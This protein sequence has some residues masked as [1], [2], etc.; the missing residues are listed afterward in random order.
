M[1]FANPPGIAAFMQDNVGY[2]EIGGRAIKDAVDQ[3]LTTMGTMGQAQSTG[4]ATIAR[5]RA[6]DLRREAQMYAN[7]QEQST[8]NTMAG[9]NAATSLFTMGMNSGMFGG[10]AVTPTP[11]P[12]RTMPDAPTQSGLGLHIDGRDL[13]IGYPNVG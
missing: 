3:D 11:T 2:D 12:P 1:R 5:D 10:G 7:Q 4:L 13:G 6:A 8:A 9:L